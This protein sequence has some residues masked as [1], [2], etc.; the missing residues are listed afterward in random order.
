MTGV[1]VSGMHHSGTSVVSGLLASSGWHPG[2]SLVPRDERLGKDFWE[3]SEF[4]SLNQSW[5]S[6]HPKDDE[7]PNDWGIHG[8]SF[9]EAPVSES[10]I[11]LARDFVNKRSRISSHWIAKDPRSAL[12]L[13]IWA[14]VPSLKFLLVYRNPWD[15]V[16]SLMRFGEPFSGRARWALSVWATYN[17]QLLRAKQAPGERCLLVSSSSVIRDPYKFRDVYSNWTG[18]SVPEFNSKEVINPNLFTHRPEGSEVS[19]IFHDLFPNE[20]KLLHNLDKQAAIPR[21]T[22]P[23]KHSRLFPGGHSKTVDAVQVV[24]PCKDDGQFLLEAIASV[25]SASNASPLPVELAII[26]SFSRDPETLRILG[27]LGDFGY[28]VVKANRKGLPAARNRGIIESKSRVV[29]PLDADNRLIPSMFSNLK[30]ILEDK[31]DIVYDQWLRFGLETRLVSPPQE[32]DWEALI[33]HNTL[34]SCAAVSRKVIDALGGWDKSLTR[35]LED[36]DFWIR[37]LKT[38]ARFSF[39]PEPFFEYFVRPYSMTWFMKDEQNS[40]KSSYFSVVKKHRRFARKI[41][42]KTQVWDGIS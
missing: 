14:S 36:W 18:K 37:A 34:D 25:E 20:S 24:I 5:L 7:T 9:V 21:E 23:L 42:A 13:S 28:Q 16:E 38:G 10:S 26:D 33:P 30:L 12:T 6:I 22:I 32:I 19:R 27:R 39:T 2:N 35:G 40:R 3:D 1:I 8:D 17:Q 11:S 29:I 31:A 15:V 41:G 4:V